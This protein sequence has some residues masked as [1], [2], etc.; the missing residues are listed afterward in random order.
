MLQQDYET[1]IGGRTYTLTRMGAKDQFEAECI[2]LHLLGPS[3]AAGA[4]TLI[5][6]FAAEIVAMIREVA[7]TGEDFDLAKLLALYTTIQTKD[8][9][10]R[11]SWLR[12]LA[13]LER[14]GGTILAD[15]VPALTDR[16]AVDKV[17]RLFELAVLGQL[18]ATVDSR[19]VRVNT[20]DALDKLL[21]GHPWHKWELLAEALRFNYSTDGLDEP[22]AEAT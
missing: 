6:T 7:G 14:L 9:Q 8:A 3:A 2:L 11:E 12:L 4:G 13:A 1:Q 18:C 10:V 21:A 22:D 15:I 20:Y 19:V 17:L 5:D 16:L